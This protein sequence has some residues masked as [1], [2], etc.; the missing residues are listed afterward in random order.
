MKFFLNIFFC[1]I[2]LFCSAQ[3]HEENI[4]KT[5]VATNTLTVKS[6]TSTTIYYRTTIKVKEDT[7]ASIYL[8]IVAKIGN[9]FVGVWLANEKTKGMLFSYVY[10]KGNETGV[11]EYNKE[12]MAVSTSGRS[13]SFVEKSDSV[14]L[15]SKLN[16]QVLE[17]NIVEHYVFK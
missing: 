15:P 10:G 6:H 16:K 4:Y 3:K 13:M 14:Y 5:C 12:Y 11:F 9:E 1:L 8:F 7:I 17:K 2:V